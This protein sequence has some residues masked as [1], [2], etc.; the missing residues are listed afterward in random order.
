MLPSLFFEGPALL[1]PAALLGLLVLVLVVFFGGLWCTVVRSYPVLLSNT[2]AHFPPCDRCSSSRCSAATRC[3]SASA[4]RSSASSASRRSSARR[5]SSSAR[6]RSSSAR[7]SSS[8]CAAANAL[9]ISSSSLAASASARRRAARAA[10]SFASM[11]LLVIVVVVV[12]IGTRERKKNCLLKSK[13]E[14]L[15]SFICQPFCAR[16]SGFGPKGEILLYASTR[17]TFQFILRHSRHLFVLP[18]MSPSFP[19][20]IR[21][22]RLFLLLT[23]R[24]RLSSSLRLPS[25]VYSFVTD[26]FRPFYVPSIIP[27]ICGY[28]II[29]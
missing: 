7:R 22:R 29:L 8:S 27:R 11:S 25:F 6:R 14:N 24:Y 26:L 9:N 23:V 3:R 19:S 18:V 10:S 5:A 13:D 1:D 21:H 20:L 4:R 17:V 16:T 2:I 12:M 15:S 28:A